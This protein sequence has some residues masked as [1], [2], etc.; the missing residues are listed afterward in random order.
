MRTVL[1]ILVFLIFSQQIV[2]KLGIDFSRLVPLSTYQCLKKAGYTF[3]VARG[4]N[5]DGSLSK[6]A[7]QNIKNSKIA[8]LSTDVYTFPCRGKNATI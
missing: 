3:F 1:A 7:L 8:G 5:P 4:H 6:N 2:C